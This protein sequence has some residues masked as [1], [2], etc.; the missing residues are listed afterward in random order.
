MLLAWVFA[1]GAGVVNACVLTPSWVDHHANGEHEP[2]EVWVSDGSVVL[3]G[4]PD[5]RAVDFDAKRQSAS[6]EACLK[7]CADESSALSKSNVPAVDP[8]L[9]VA[10]LLAWWI[11]VVLV[12]HIGPS[13]SLEHRAVPEPP[14]V[15]RFLRLTL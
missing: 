7:F 4:P 11:P 12:A 8:S 10:A 6:H 15:I 3:P 5:D 13:H 9:P 2:H 14:L 1:L